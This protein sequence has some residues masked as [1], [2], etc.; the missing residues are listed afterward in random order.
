MNRLTGSARSMIGNTNLETHRFN[1][2]QI[3]I[4]KLIITQFRGLGFFPLNSDGKKT[5]WRRRRKM[6]LGVR[7][8]GKGSVSV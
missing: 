8:G 2:G 1:S 6:M 4:L 3:F 5:L 7:E